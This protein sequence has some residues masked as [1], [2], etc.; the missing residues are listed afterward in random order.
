MPATNQLLSCMRRSRM[1]RAMATLLAMEGGLMGPVMM[2]V[3]VGLLLLLG[4][5]LATLTNLS[6]R[7]LRMLWGCLRGKSSM[8]SLGYLRVEWILLL[9]FRTCGWNR[10]ACSSAGAASSAAV[11]RTAGWPS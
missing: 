3:M 4:K 2:G 9:L 11:P 8:R 7:S 1:T 5:Q 10:A 6:V